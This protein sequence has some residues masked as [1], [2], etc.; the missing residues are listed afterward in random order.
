MKGLYGKIDS[1]KVAAELS[2]PG[3]SMAESTA[4]KVNRIKRQFTMTHSGI[5]AFRGTEQSVSIG[6]L[7]IR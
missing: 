7:I 5:C 2:L 6:K 1:V 4:A 3:C